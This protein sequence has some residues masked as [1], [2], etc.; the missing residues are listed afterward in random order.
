MAKRRL[1]ASAM[2]LG[3]GATG[4]SAQ[5]TAGMEEYI[6]SCAACHGL[7]GQGNGPVAEY[8][9][10]EVPDL[11]RLALANDGEFPMLQ[12]IRIIDGRTGVRAHGSRMPVWGGRY[13][14]A[15]T[16]ETGVYGAELM[17]RARIL[18]L[19]THLDAIQE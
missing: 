19:A 10:V 16:P 13:L 5:S 3:L 11:T 1:L 8:M 12:V 9:R 15:F 18:A 4:A 6:H 7:T 14:Q 17:V 2:A